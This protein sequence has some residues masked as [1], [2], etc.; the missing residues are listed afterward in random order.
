MHLGLSVLMGFFWIFCQDFKGPLLSDYTFDWDRVLQAQGD[1][2]V[3]LQ[4]THA[5]LCRFTLKLTPIGF[6]PVK[7]E[8]IC[9][10][11]VIAAWCGAARRQERVN[12]THPSCSKTRV[13]PSCSTFYGQQTRHRWQTAANCERS[14]RDSSAPCLQLWRGAPPVSSGSAAQTSGQLFTEAQVGERSVCVCV[15]VFAAY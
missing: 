6:K 10:N 3:F 13:S 2:G 4:Y 7:L 5:R 14:R 8:C 15:S 12:L 1:T 11:V 9:H